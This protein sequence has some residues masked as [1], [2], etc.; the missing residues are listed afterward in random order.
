M[1][2]HDYTQ[3]NTALWSDDDWRTLTSDEQWLYFLLWTHPDLSAAGVLDWRPGKLSGFAID[4]GAADLRGIAVTLQ[5]KRFILIDEDTEEVLVRPYIRRDRNR[6]TMP[7]T[8]KGMCRAFASTG[9]KKIRQ[10]IVHEVQKAHSRT[11]DLKGFVSETSRADLFDLMRQPANPIESFVDPEGMGSDV[12]PQ[13]IDSASPKVAEIQ[14][15]THH[16][17]I[18]NSSPLRKTLDDKQRRPSEGHVEGQGSGHQGDSQTEASSA[19][20]ALI[21]PEEAGP[22]LEDF[23]DQFWGHW[24][25]KMK[26][27]AALKAFTRAVKEKRATPERIVQGAEIYSWSKLP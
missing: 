17:G 4:K 6:L 5:Q 14:T 21:E 7:N 18:E 22:S 27:P 15:G 1:G 11:P 20:I 25:K 26:K 8:A 24:P 12:D 2:G 10:V 9:S 16:K 13:G 3:V 19:E 23:F